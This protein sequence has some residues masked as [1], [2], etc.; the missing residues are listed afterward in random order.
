MWSMLFCYRNRNFRTLPFTASRSGLSQVGSTGKSNG[1]LKH[2]AGT[3][4]SLFAS[5]KVKRMRVWAQALTAEKRTFNI[6]EK[7]SKLG[8]NYFR[9]PQRIFGNE[10]V[11]RRLGGNGGNDFRPRQH[12]FDNS[13]SQTKL[14]WGNG[15]R[16][17]QRAF[18]KLENQAKLSGKHDF[19][20]RQRALNSH[21]NFTKYGG[22]NDFRAR[23]DTFFTRENHTAFGRRN[24][25]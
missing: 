6:R 4:D 21:E 15:F 24:N 14:G 11:Q 17:R 5:M 9:A 2:S 25:Y 8:E 7:K 16:V 12:T 19:R 13:G 1:P 10:E 22:G 23:K 18:D 20:M 3:L